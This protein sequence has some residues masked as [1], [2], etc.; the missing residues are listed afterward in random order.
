LTPSGSGDKAD[1]L[2]SSSYSVASIF[3]ISL[4]FERQEVNSAM[5]NH[6]EINQLDL[7]SQ[8][9]VDSVS[10]TFQTSIGQ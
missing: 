7:E 6:R 1:E 4:S 2:C 9:V 5:H 3:S 8:T 10:Y